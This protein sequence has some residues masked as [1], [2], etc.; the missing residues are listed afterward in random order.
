MFAGCKSLTKA[1]ELPATTLATLCY[2]GM[3]DHCS[4]LTQAP[5]VLPATTLADDCYSW[6]FYTCTSL[7]KAPELPAT[8][9]SNNCY[10]NMFGGCSSLT[11]IKLG[12]VGDFST[13]YFNNWV[14][15]TSSKG[16]FYYNGSDTTRGTSA[17]PNGWN[18]IKDK[19]S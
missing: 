4:S 2:N 6:M 3:F 17:I 9:L 19:R 8:T 10:Q 11:S 14:K 15:N 16:T 13:T 1:P 5:I 7:T 12:Y 18:V